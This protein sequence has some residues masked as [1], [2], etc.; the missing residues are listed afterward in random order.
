MTTS[1]PSPAGKG[2][3]VSVEENDRI[4]ESISWDDAKAYVVNI[5]DKINRGLPLEVYEE[6][7]LQGFPQELIDEVNREEAGKA[8]LVRLQQLREQEIATEQ[9]MSPEEHQKFVQTSPEAMVLNTFIPEVFDSNAFFSI[10]TS[11]EGMDPAAFVDASINTIAYLMSLGYVSGMWMTGPE[12]NAIGAKNPHDVCSPIIDGIP[13]CDRL[14][15]SE[16][17][18]EDALVRA[19]MHA[20]QHG[21]YPP[22]AILSYSHPNCKCSINCWAPSTPEEIPDSAPGVPMFGTPEERLYYKQHIH[23]NLRDFQVD[24][25][26]V[27]SPIVYE[28]ES[29]KAGIFNQ[30]SVVRGAQ[31]YGER[32]RFAKSEWKEDIKPVAVKEGFIIKSEMGMYRPVPNTYFGLQVEQNGEHC[33]VYLGD[34]GR[35]IIAPLEKIEEINIKSVNFSEIDSN[36]YIKVDD[37]IGIVIKVLAEDKILC[38]VPDLDERIIIESGEIFERV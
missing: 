15:A 29:A 2:A 16:I 28:S 17:I 38:Y 36:M 1:S 6:Q 22:K 19:T 25:W 7:L 13:V 3:S 31:V 35:V 12:H 5:Y 18:L 14:D 32:V 8:P 26:T 30:Y 21:Y 10:S 34:L 11:R 20:N 27:L 9:M 24:R 37:T 4:K 33:R 23:K